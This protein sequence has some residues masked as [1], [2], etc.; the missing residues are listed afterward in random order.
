MSAV[1][2]ESCYSWIAQGVQHQRWFPDDVA[3]IHIIAHESCGPLFPW[4]RKIWQ[5][6]GL[7][8]RFLLA[9]EIDVV[10]F[11]VFLETTSLQPQTVVVVTLDIEPSRKVCIRLI[12]LCSVYKGLH[13]IILISNPLHKVSLSK[14]IP[15]EIPK[16]VDYNLFATLSVLINYNVHDKQTI[17]S[18]FDRVIHSAPK[19]TL[20][21][22]CAVI[23]YI[24]VLGRSKDQF[25]STWL[26]VLIKENLSLFTLSQHLLARDARSFY[27]MWNDIY[28]RYPDEFWLVYWSDQ[29]WQAYRFTTSQRSSQADQ[30]SLFTKGLPFSFY[31]KRMAQLP[32]RI[33][34]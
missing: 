34:C 5:Q 14:N 26:P 21:Q 1:R 28:P 31:S 3:Y 2:T 8:V 33:I 32:S 22:A 4:L 12:E 11:E 23:P 6:H 16:I 30:S 18:F 24:D 20:A 15:I 9:S 17:K 25:Y 13:R 29:L 19:L 7:S 27:A 10:E